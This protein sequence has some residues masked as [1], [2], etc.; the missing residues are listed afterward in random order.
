MA[1]DNT[2]TGQVLSVFVKCH[3]M[4]LDCN[5]VCSI[6]AKDNNWGLIEDALRTYTNKLLVCWDAW[7]Q[8]R[9]FLLELSIGSCF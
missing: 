3:Y 1:D 6:R 7:A 4:F 2:S 9:L 8:V 5:F